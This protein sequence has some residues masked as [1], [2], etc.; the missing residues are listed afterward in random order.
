MRAISHDFISASA[1]LAASPI[2][3]ILSHMAHIHKNFGN[4]HNSLL[5]LISIFF[6]AVYGDSVAL[7]LRTLPW[8]TNQMFPDPS[9]SHL[10][11]MPWLSGELALWMKRVPRKL[12]L[13]VLTL[14]L[15]SLPFSSRPIFNPS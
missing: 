14:C 13:G 1:F 4:S 6:E 11:I 9:E 12:K 10:Q 7:L 5:Q 8:P 2:N 3:I 15:R